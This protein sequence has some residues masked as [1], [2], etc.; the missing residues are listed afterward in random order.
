MV[1]RKSRYIFLAS[2]PS[3]REELEPSDVMTLPNTLA[4][5][6]KL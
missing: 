6:A 5:A 2:F 4:Q 3:L 1:Q